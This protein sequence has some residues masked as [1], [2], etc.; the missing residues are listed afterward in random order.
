MHSRGFEKSN[1][2][3]VNADLMPHEGG[4]RNRETRHC[5]AV[6][7]KKRGWPDGHPALF[8]D[9]YCGGGVPRKRPTYAAFATVLPSIAASSSARPAVFG[10]SRFALSA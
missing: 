4:V 9:C 2:S 8:S 7:R 10:R 1:E 6:E 5:S 3:G